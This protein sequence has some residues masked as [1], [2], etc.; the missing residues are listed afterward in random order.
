MIRETKTQEK[1]IFTLPF[2]SLFCSLVFSLFVAELSSPSEALTESCDLSAPENIA[3][4][5]WNLLKRQ[6]QTLWRFYHGKV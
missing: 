2:S 3:I 1:Q 4:L 5:I 6:K